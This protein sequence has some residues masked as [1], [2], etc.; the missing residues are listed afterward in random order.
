MDVAAPADGDGL[1]G[2]LL[3]PMEVIGVV[4]QGFDAVDMALP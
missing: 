2:R 1:P 4:G 3:Q